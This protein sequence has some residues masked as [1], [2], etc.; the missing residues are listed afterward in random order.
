MERVIKEIWRASDNQTRPISNTLKSEIIYKCHKIVAEASNASEAIG[1][2][3]QELIATK[4]NS[5]ISEFAKR[6]IP[7]AFQSND[8]TKSWR[9]NFFSELTNY[10]PFI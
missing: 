7:S 9:S 1:K 5:I 8:P 2:F 6:A 3:N 4:S 10:F